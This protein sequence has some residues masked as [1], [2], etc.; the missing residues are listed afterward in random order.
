MWGAVDLVPMGDRVLVA[1][2]H[3][4]NP[5]MDAGEIEVT[6][7]DA[8]RIVSASGYASHGE[9]VRRLRNARGKVADIW[10][11]SANIKPQQVLAREIERRYPARKR[12]IQ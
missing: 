9:P 7:R 12:R 1:S 10:L 11:A 6:G 4:N 8:G 3:L 5:F 2:P